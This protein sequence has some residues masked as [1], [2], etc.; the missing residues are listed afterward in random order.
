MTVNELQEELIK[1]IEHI[2]E[3]METYNHH[4]N[5]ARVKGYQQAIPAFTPTEY[6]EY[7]EQAE[8]A[9]F[10]YFVVVIDDAIYHNPEADGNNTAHVMVI[11]GIYDD[12]EKMRGYFTL[13]A[14]MQRVI[15]RFVKN[16]IMG[17]FY[18]DKKMR[19]E[20]QEDNTAPQFFGG[21]EMIWYLP[22]IEMEEIE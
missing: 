2:T 22:E 4:G 9:L 10:P 20:F 21:I 1:E 15:T 12:D 13:S 7:D 17:L 3:D 5:R 16:N 18:C 6:G 11:F 19:M 8:D 14:I